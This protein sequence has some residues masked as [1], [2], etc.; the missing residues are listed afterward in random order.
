[1]GKPIGKRSHG[2]SRSRWEDQI[3]TDTRKIGYEDGRWLEQA[4][5]CV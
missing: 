5:E 4:Q 2:S 3:W 1:M